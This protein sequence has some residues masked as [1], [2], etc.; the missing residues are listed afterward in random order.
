MATLITKTDI[1]NYWPLSL[2]IDDARVNPWIEKAEYNRLSATLSPELFFAL[3]EATI[4]PGDRF[5]KLL[6]GDKYVDAGNYERYFEGVKPL[7][8][9]YSFAYIIENNAVHVTR[10][11]VNRKAGEQTENTTTRE[12]NDRG[13][14][15]YSEAIR[16]EGEFYKYLT[17]KTGV[18]PEYQ[19]TRPNKSGSFNFFNASKC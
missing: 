17:A 4:T 6:N 9:A 8:A 5:D 1:L 19:G 16:L 15:A 11:G 3:K 10:G 14:F 12:N 13:Q 2:N 7:L 18:Y